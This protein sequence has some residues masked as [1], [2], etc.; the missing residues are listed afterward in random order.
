MMMLYVQPLAALSWGHLTVQYIPT[1]GHVQ[2]TCWPAK[3][4]KLHCA[5]HR[6]V[7]SK[8]SGV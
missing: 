7:Y 8:A 2:I 6:W 1:S 4:R 5:G 3:A